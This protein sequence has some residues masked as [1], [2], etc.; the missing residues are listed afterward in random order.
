MAAASALRMKITTDPRVIQEKSNHGVTMTGAIVRPGLRRDY[1]I[2]VLRGLA[3]LSVLLLHFH[4]AY[5]LLKSPMALLLP[6]PYLV[7]LV[8]N[9]NYGVTVFFVI[10]GYLITSTSLKRFGSLG[11]I[12][13]RSFYA[14][15]F[16]RIVPCLLLV[17]A[18]ITGLALANVPAFG[19]T[20][21]VSIW[22][23][24]LSVLTF[25]HNVMMVKYGYFN[26]C[27][28]VFWSLSVEEAFYL[29]FPLLCRGCAGRDGLCRP[30]L[31]P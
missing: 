12:S 20:R 8:W 17:L 11:G 29:G 28:D 1:R 9:G 3:I 4:F 2:D 31:L 27:L 21:N 24:D 26:Y 18:I 25:W 6:K 22:L 15:R 13:A 16:A 7:N 23:A 30:G 19:D 5:N 10:S 14:F